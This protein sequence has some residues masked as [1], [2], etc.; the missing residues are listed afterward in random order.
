MFAY[1]SDYLGKKRTQSKCRSITALVVLLIVFFLRP[2]SQ[3]SALDAF[4]VDSLH[5]DMVVGNDNTYVITETY[6]MDFSEERHGFI[7]SLPLMTY[8]NR[9]CCSMT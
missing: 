2:A 9:R 6:E 4:E 8:D 5:I 7:R 3:I 1:N